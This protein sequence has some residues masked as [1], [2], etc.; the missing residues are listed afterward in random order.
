MSIKG[1][2]RHKNGKAHPVHGKKGVDEKS[3]SVTEK[4]M[5]DKIEVKIDPKKKH[6]EDKKHDK[7]IFKYPLIIPQSQFLLHKMVEALKKSKYNDNHDEKES[8]KEGFNRGVGIAEGIT[9]EDMTKIKIGLNVENL[10]FGP[11]AVNLDFHEIRNAE[12]AKDFL[13]HWAYDA[14]ENDRQSSDFSFEAHELNERE[15]DEEGMPQSDSWEAFQDG[16]NEGINSYFEKF[17]ESNVS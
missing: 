12:D 11:D 17:F 13:K 5:N 15:T 7:S 2:G 8:F 10:D 4:G 14:G 3:F 6:T 1:F 9:N 16:V